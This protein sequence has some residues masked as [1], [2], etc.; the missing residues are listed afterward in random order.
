MRLP[1]LT[2]PDYLPGL[3]VQFARRMRMFTV[4]NQSSV[5]LAPDVDRT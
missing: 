1:E 4:P 5:A 2:K 3:D